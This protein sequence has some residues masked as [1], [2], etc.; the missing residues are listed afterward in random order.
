MCYHAVMQSNTNILHDWLHRRGI[1]AEVIEMFG[2]SPYEHRDI[3]ECIKI[4]ITP[5]WNKYRRN[6]LDERKPKYLYDIGGKVTLYGYDKLHAEHTT[7]LITEGEADCL[8]AWSHN[9]PAVTSTGGAMSFQ[10]EWAELLSSYEVFL[11]FDNDDA[12]AEGMVKVLRYIPNAKVVLVPEK[13]GVKDIS[14]YVG[15]G[16]DL[17]ALMATAKSY[18]S[19][20]DVLEDMADR[21]AHWQSVRFHEKYVDAHRQKEERA[22]TPSP[23]TG[24]D[25][26]ARAKAYPMTNLI[27][28]TRGKAC[29][30]WH[31]ERTP[32][33]QY[34]PKTNSAYC[35]GKCGR[36]YDSID[37]YRMAHQCGFKQAV[38]ELGKL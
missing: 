21:K 9:I 20:T 23:Y 19:I 35:F 32:S 25:E 13:S 8:V 29:C 18:A 15:R 22:T 14:D 33:L 17:H 5:E 4:P 6:P 34:Y 36:A 3:G 16:G 38:E 1:T 11:C 26:V 7:V 24:T 28:F 37:A 27:E 30:P 10:E 2:I 12:G 31:S